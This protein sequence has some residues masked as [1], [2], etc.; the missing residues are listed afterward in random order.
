VL[1]VAVAVVLALAVAACGGAADDAGGDSTGGAAS[2]EASAAASAAAGPAS[3][4]SPAPNV[5]QAAP[6]QHV[7]VGDLSVGYRTIGPTGGAAAGATPLLLIMGSTSTMDIWSPELVAALAE[8][9]QVVVFDNRGIGETDDPGGAYEFSQLADDTAGL[10]GALG[11]E[12]MDVLGWSMGAMVA[13]DLAVRHPEVVSRLVSYAGDP[14][15]RHSVPMG[16]ETLAVLED[17]S[18][19]PQQMGERL[20]ELLFPAAYRSANPA[21]A[22]HF[23]IPQEQAS[24]AAIGLQDRAI[25]EWAGVWSGLGGITS[26][27]LFVTGTDDV[28]APARNS[29]VLT[30]KVPGSWLARFPGAGHGLMYQDPAGLAAVVLTFLDLPE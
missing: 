23:P 6:V 26:P 15:G 29:V 3:S 25:G 30:A 4:G 19:T 1:V 5:V 24:P 7:K 11:H 28:I 2:P 9:R 12:K 27:T 20:L 18:G 8:G 13:L 10:I 16:K 17:T 21:Y 22:E 14:G